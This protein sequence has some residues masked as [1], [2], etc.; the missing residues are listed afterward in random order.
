MVFNWTEGPLAEGLECYREGRFFDAHEHWESVWLTSPHPEKKFVQ[1]LIH[2]TV[3]FHHLRRDNRVGA[4]RQLTAA[5]R[6][7]ELYAGEFGGIEV[8][9]LR[10]ALRASIAAIERGD[11]LST[12]APPHI[13]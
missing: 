7:L 11:P 10:D 8:A 3:G 5:L 6:K 13:Y 1:A 4:T 9:T 12:V 2:I